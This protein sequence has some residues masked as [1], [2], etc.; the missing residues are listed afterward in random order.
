MVGSEVMKKVKRDEVTMFGQIAGEDSCHNCVDLNKQ[1]TEKVIPK[2]T[3]PV[4]YKHYSVYNDEEGKKVAAA[5][6][7]K[8]IPYV[9]HCKIAEDDTKQC[10]TVVGYDPDNWKNVGKPREEKFK[11]I[12]PVKTT[13]EPVIQPTKAA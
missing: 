4:D 13:T 12:E 11:V 9:K 2:A 8:D 6:N 1:M 5:E 3:I 7:I 10:D